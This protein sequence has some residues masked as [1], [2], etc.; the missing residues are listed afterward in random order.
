MCAGAACRVRAE[1][2]EAGVEYGLCSSGVAEAVG[3]CSAVQR[4]VR[5]VPCW[6]RIRMPADRVF[7]LTSHP[8]VKHSSVFSRG[9]EI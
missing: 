3:D 7:A 8:P 4:W 2:V 6:T 5:K 9:Q 1:G